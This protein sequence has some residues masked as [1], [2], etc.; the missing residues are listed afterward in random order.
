MMRGSM[1]GSMRGSMRSGMRGSM[2]SG[3]E[4]S[5]SAMGSGSDGP[6]DRNT[7]LIE[8]Y[9]RILAVRPSEGFAFQR[10]LDLYRERDGNIDALVTRLSARVTADADD[11]GSRMLLGHVLKAQGNATR[12]RELYEAAA[13]LNA[14]AP[15]PLIA[16]G[17]IDRAAGR[18]AEARGHYERA[19]E[20]LEEGNERRELYR[21]LGEIALDA[22]DY[23]AARGYY[24]R[25]GGG[26]RASI[27]VRTEFARALSARNKHERAVA[28][29]QR[30]MRQLRGD[31]RVLA[32][33]LRDMGQAQLEAGD[34][35][36]AIA[37]LDRALRV[38]G[39]SSGIR[40]EIYD[41]IVEAYRRGERLPE[42]VERL[43]SE[44]RRDFSSL[45][46]LGRLHD[47][48][49]DEEEALSSYRAALRVNRRSIDTRVRIIQLL[50]RSGRMDDVTREYRDLI[51]VA[52]RE[53]RFVVELAQLLAQTGKRDEA[54]RIAAQTSRRYPREGSVHQALAELYTEWGETELA[55]REMAILVRIDPRDPAHLIALGE[56]Q[57]EEGRE[58]AALATWRRI[59]TVAGSGERAEAHAT[60]GGVLADHDH[61]DEAEEQYRRAVALEDDRVEYIRGLANVL[62]RP[63]QGESRGDRRRRN[64]EA[65][66]QWKRALELGGADRAARREARQRIV[67]IYSRSG[68]L[69][70]RIR[71]WRVAFRG[72]PPD[73]DAGRFLAEGYL[74]MRPRNA[75]MAERTLRRVIEVEP[76]DVESLLALERALTARG[77]LAGAI[78]ILEKL[79]DADPRRAA[80]YLQRMAEHSHA[81]YRD[82]D[83]VRYAAAAV[84]RTPDDADAHRRLGD[85]YRARQDMPAA[86]AS[87]RRAIELNE[88]HF[89]T[90]FDLAEMHLSR[91][92][93]MDADRLLRGV[94]R[95]SP[96]D[97]L[98]AR[99]ARSSMQI[100]TGADSLEVLEQDLLPLAL[101]NPRRPVF[102]KLLVELY[103]TLTT[104]W[105]QRA[106]LGG[107][108]G[109]IA[110]E[111][112]RRLGTRALKPLLEALA[113]DE[114]TQKRIAID[115]LGH[116]G[117]ANAAA[118]L[119]AAAEGE[120]DVTLR[121]RALLG[122]G[123]VA[124]ESLAGRFVAITRDGDRLLRPVAAWSLARIGGRTAVSAM[125]GL[126]SSGDPSVRAFAAMGLGRARD[127]VSASAVEGLL[128]EDRNASVQV[129]AAWALGRY[130]S[131]AHV[132]ALVSSLSD[133][134]GLVARA[135]AS[136]LGDIG[137]PRATNALARALFDTDLAQRRAA[138]AALARLG[139]GDNEEVAFPV[140]AGAVNLRGYAP[141]LLA[142]G[143]VVTPTDLAPLQ[144]ALSEAALDALHGPLENVTTALAVLAMPTPNAKIGF[145]E[146]TAQ[147]ATWPAEGRSAATSVLNTMA[148][149]IVPAIRATASH[150]QS[151]VRGLA[152]QRLSVLTGPEVDAALAEALADPEPSVQRIAL[153][154]MGARHGGPE[155]AG[156]VAE[157]AENHEDWSTRRL[158]CQTLARLGET[159]FAS[160]LTRIAEQ[161]EY[162]FVREA[163]TQALVTLGADSSVARDDEEPRVRAAADRQD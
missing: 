133:R 126:L 101:G 111:S 98:V 66:E 84:E 149:A 71:S 47:E 70:D 51:R 136:A 61:L 137:D 81:L 48:L 22:D 35:E 87:Y 21:E 153:S 150:P 141:L 9:E 2:R 80:H 28:E 116:L 68:E 105:I 59:L 19:A 7:V 91:G 23:D 62:E 130:G 54:L 96:D 119:L 43:S 74:R 4:G 159:S 142:R 3:M 122:A 117:N 121:A 79:T 41:V 146:L 29:Y 33:V 83:A 45:E 140:P 97:D 134:A 135:S 144:T 158:A 118:P 129:A 73:A 78:G 120:G 138:A 15:E 93:M 125:R 13:A 36:S 113:D 85:L 102:R 123:A 5:A 147:L 115:I 72:N 76:G 17:R 103:E 42:L 90:Y 112:L 163:A 110:D 157:I 25:V 162:A 156:R 38:A 94:V 151:S 104:P 30:V 18:H 95:G 152:V 40:R 6:R 53:P 100:H 32:P 12:A 58:S 148:R 64:T 37:T 10:L 131:P 155:A 8:R 88:R 14:R 55:S 39:R 143:D 31:N 161:D 99:A 86:I 69:A 56:Q 124:R 77:D 132:P 49:G 139:R 89:T 63:R 108:D 1:G 52:P 154:S 20:R 67:G 160:V 106:R 46:L 57:L 24:D 82:E 60:L 114:P 107:E 128:R 16:M 50:A 34:A 26:S 109:A 11:F 75:L 127:R 145:G 27:Y 65:V 92:E 44:R